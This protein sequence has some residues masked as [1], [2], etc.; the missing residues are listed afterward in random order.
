MAGC[1]VVSVILGVWEG[2]ICKAA[3]LGSSKEALHF[4]LGASQNCQSSGK[5]QPLQM[6]K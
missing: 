2:G 5:T 1:R 6:S 4:A 3:A